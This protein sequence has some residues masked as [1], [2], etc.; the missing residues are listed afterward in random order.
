M[1]VVA[2]LPAKGS[3]SRIKSKN[4][5]LLDGTPLFLYTL[6][7]LVQ[8]EFID[9][10]YLDT[11]SE[12]VIE[13]ASE[14]DCKILKRNSELS[15]NATDGN[16]LFLNEIAHVQADIY[17]QVLCT[18][19][20]ISGEKIKQGV[21]LLKNT[22]NEY[23]SVVLVRKEKLYTWN[24][25]GPVY[26]INK[27]PNSVDLDDTII[28]TMGLYISKREV[29][30]STNRRIGNKPY[31]MEASPLEAIDVNWPEDFKLA[32]LIA[33][34]LREKDCKLLANIKNL[35]SSC[36]LSDILDNFGYNLQIIKGLTPNID[37]VKVLGRAKTLK[38]R[39]IRENEDFK[40]IYDALCSYKTIVP[41]D[42]IV[43]ENETPEFAY[44]GELNANM[45]IREGAS[46]VILNGKT[47]DSKEVKS[48]GF[49]VFSSGY[50]CQDVRKRATTESFNKTIYVNGVKVSP[51]DLVYGDNEGIVVIPRQIEEKVIKEACKRASNEKRILTDIS[52]GVDVSSIM[53]N[54]GFF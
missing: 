4:L 47:R 43:V 54:Y 15:S 27:I 6:K 11:E 17:I 7:N 40:G 32:E 30:L 45:A 52:A 39:K 5:K 21:E 42:I 2:F 3:S 37:G 26:D 48:I 18:S 24:N 12:E 22:D 46:C 8:Y 33:A 36:M 31:L 44:F 49:P 53:K 51:G 34:G 20:F 38:L 41:N 10:V 16:M 23:D 29:A 50:T 1:K 13:L 25:S 28:E 9:E 14:V 35:L 19:P